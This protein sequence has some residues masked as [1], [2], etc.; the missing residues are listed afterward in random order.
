M[1]V[2]SACN[3]LR[4]YLLNREVQPVRLEAAERHPT[5]LPHVGLV[6]HVR[7]DGAALRGLVG[8]GEQSLAALRPLEL[9]G[10][11]DLFAL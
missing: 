2:G 11:G 1:V 7:H 8:H 6:Q 10:H 4:T 5:P 9:L 3:Q